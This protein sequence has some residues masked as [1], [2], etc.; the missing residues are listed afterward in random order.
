MMDDGFHSILISSQSLSVGCGH[1]RNLHCG[2][3]VLI[4]RFAQNG[5]SAVRFGPTSGVRSVPH[6]SRCGGTR[7]PKESPRDERV[8]HHTENS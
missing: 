5:L 2:S 6:L 4:V 1:Q 8:I 3:L 7:V